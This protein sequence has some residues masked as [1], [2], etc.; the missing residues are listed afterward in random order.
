MDFNIENNLHGLFHFGHYLSI[1]ISRLQKDKK[2]S[3]DSLKHFRTSIQG[4]DPD[5]SPVYLIGCVIISHIMYL[6]ANDP[7]VA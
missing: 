5:I 2:K 3:E 4:Q 7:S 6:Q 1:L